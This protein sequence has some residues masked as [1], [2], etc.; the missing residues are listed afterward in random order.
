MSR[1]NCRC[2]LILQNNHKWIHPR[3][4]C[5]YNIQ[6]GWSPRIWCWGRENLWNSLLLYHQLHAHG[7]LC[8]SKHDLL[9]S[10]GVPLSSRVQRWPLKSVSMWSWLFKH[11]LWHCNDICLCWRPLLELLRSLSLWK[12]VHSL[13]LHAHHLSDYSR[14]VIHWTFLWSDC[15]SAH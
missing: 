10:Y 11:S 2:F 7:C 4:P 1:A 9:W 8:D 5:P 6:H 12:E 3:Q 15:R 14:L 13:V